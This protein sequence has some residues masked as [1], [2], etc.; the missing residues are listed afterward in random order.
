MR[1]PQHDLCFCPCIP[2]SQGAYFHGGLKLAM[3]DQVEP[4]VGP[5]HYS[6]GLHNLAW[7]A[8]DC[9]LKDEHFQICIQL[10]KGLGRVARNAGGLEKT[11]LWIVLHTPQLRTESKFQ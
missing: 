6:T 4:E 2:L 11:I 5:Q 7:A 8:R 9:P 3:C 1:E 10:A